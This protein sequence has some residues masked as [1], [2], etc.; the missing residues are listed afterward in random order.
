MEKEKTGHMHPLSIITESIIYAF[1]KL[2]FD[3]ADGPEVETEKFNFDMLNHRPPILIIAPGKCFRYEASDSTHD[4]QFHQVE[5]LVIDRSA[6]LA[7][8]RGTLESFFQSFF[9]ANT[10]T[11]FRPSYFPFVEPGVEVD[12]P[13]FKCGGKGGNCSSC[14]GT[15]W[16]EIMGAG[17]VHPKVLDGV[18]IDSKKWKGFAFGMSIDRLAMTRFKIPD[19]RLFYGGD[20]RVVN[21]F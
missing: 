17:C 10:K 7:E 6:S 18:G 20:L 9:G 21:Q 15:G 2:G 16:I 13:C 11:R 4:I 1:R 5:G 14:K 3:L 12:I 8:L 19:I